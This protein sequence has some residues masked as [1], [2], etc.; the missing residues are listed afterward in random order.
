VT[1]I[2]ISHLPNIITVLRILLVIPT[3]WLLLEAR[4]PEALVLMAIT[5]ASDALDGWL[6][7]RFGWT[8]GL[9]AVLDPLADKLLV[10]ATFLILTVQGHIPVWVAAIVLGRDAVI[11]A[12]AGAYR[13]FFA[14]IEFS[15]TFISKAN[16]AAQIVLLLLVLFGLCGFGGLSELVVA[17]VDPYCL[18]LLAGFGLASGVDYVVTWSRK[19][20]N[21]G[22]EGPVGEAPI[23]RDDAGGD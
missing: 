5:G 17:I 21:H 20:W 3:G 6:A 23:L 15:P 12:G 16:T 8:S 11:M 19:A 4:Y 9:G 13:L 2:S 10:A 18:Y 14:P 22:A 7:R 1:E